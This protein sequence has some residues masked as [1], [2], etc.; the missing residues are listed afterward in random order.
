MIPNRN[1]LSGFDKQAEPKAVGSQLPD[2]RL[3][4]QR[5]QEARVEESSGRDR[6]RLP[7]PQKGIHRLGNVHPRRPRIFPAITRTRDSP[8]LSKTS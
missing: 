3:Q 8:A 4:V 7:D 2:H 5:H 6:R 1:T